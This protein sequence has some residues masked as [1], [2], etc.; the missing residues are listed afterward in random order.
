MANVNK[1]LRKLFFI[2]SYP[3]SGNTWVRAFIYTLLRE[4]GTIKVEDSGLQE[5]NRFLPWDIEARHVRAATGRTP[6]DIPVPE[7]AGLRELVH[8]MIA[9]SFPGPPLVKTHALFGSFHGR[10]TINASLTG[11]A[12]YLVR[13]PLDVASSLARHFSKPV[14]GAITTMATRDYVMDS[15]EN[16]AAEPWGSWSLNVSSWTGAPNKAVLVMRYEDLL[17]DP[18][19]GF[20]R[21]A[22]H[23]GIPVSPDIVAQA[24][25]AV[26]LDRLEAIEKRGDFVSPSGRSERF[27]GGGAGRAHR[28]KL[29]AGQ[30]R[31]ILEVQAVQMQRFGYLTTDI[32]DYAG[33]EAQAVLSSSREHEAG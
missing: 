27:F 12:V 22:R 17:A 2:A 14:D 15:H 5:L 26:A 32:L 8:A 10:P 4:T 13:N 19:R 29:T 7:M 9:Q 16:A 18:E 31:R 3:R 28:D 21:I 24:T 20:L 23:L 11:G 25:R 1:S 6:E 30:V 33:V